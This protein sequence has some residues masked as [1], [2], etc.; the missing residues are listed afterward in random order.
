M[1]EDLLDH[2]LRIIK[3]LSPTNAWIASHLSRGNYLIQ[4]DWKLDNDPNQP[5][6]RSRK[7]EIIIQEE[8]IDDY[9]EK[10][11]EDRALSDI[12]IRQWISEQYDHYNH[13]NLDPDAYASN[14]ASLDKWY[15]S[16]DV[17]K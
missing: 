11:K 12:K 5:N 1:T 2:W 10:S 16:K 13:S 8:A 3:S 9:L 7:I 4:I 15:I 17:F 6:K 14:Y